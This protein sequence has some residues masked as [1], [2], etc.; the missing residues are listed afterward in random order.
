MLVTVLIQVGGL[1]GVLKFLLDLTAAH[2]MLNLEILT[3]LSSLK[4]LNKLSSFTYLV[5]SL[6]AVLSQFILIKQFLNLLFKIPTILILVPLPFQFSHLLC[7]EHFLLK[8][9]PLV[10]LLLS[11]CLLVNVAL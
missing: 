6:G 2:T 11:C 4:L 5:N 3:F 9:L 7:P 1:E 8:D 10:L